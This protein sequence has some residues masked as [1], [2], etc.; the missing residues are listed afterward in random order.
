LC[1]FVENRIFD[2][3]VIVWGELKKK[4]IKIEEAKQQPV[5]ASQVRPSVHPQLAKRNIE[6]KKTR[7]GESGLP[8]SLLPDLGAQPDTP[9]SQ[10]VMPSLYIY[11]CSSLI[12]LLNYN[13]STCWLGH[14]CH[15]EGQG[16]T[17]TN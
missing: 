14:Y 9:S 3:R 8:A 2:E 13:C 1:D 7:K 16:S 17:H 12:H 15:P 10:T 5:W 6:K 11:H 4:R